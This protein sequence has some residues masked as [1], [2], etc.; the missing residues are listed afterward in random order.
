M[1]TVE[2]NQPTTIQNTN[3]PINFLVFKV[4]EV[5]ISSAESI[6]K[7]SHFFGYGDSPDTFIIVKGRQ[8]VENHLIHMGASWYR[9]TENYVGLYM[10]SI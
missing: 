7:A 6:C 10:L 5:K 4:V 2:K 9:H 8:T 3:E 1:V